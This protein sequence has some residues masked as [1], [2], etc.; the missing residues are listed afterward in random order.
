MQRVTLP[1]HELREELLDNPNRKG[2]TA[3]TYIHLLN[4]TVWSGIILTHHSVYRDWEAVNSL[5]CA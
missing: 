3:P 5:E 4:D 1:Q 2:S